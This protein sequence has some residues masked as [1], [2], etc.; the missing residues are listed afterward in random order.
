MRTITWLCV[1]VL[2]MLH[3]SMNAQSPE[4]YITETDYYHFYINREEPFNKKNLLKA[5]EPYTGYISI[6]D[7]SVFWD[8]VPNAAK[9]LLLHGFS[10]K[11]ILFINQQISESAG[12]VWQKKKLAATK[13][14]DS[15]KKL[16]RRNRFH[17]LGV[18]LFSLDKT[19]C[20]IKEGTSCRYVYRRRANYC[21]L[22]EISIYSY[23][24]NKWVRIKVIGG[25]ITVT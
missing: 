8:N 6:T 10:E 17:A 2:L 20:I 15:D 11:D 7:T 25:M 9:V 12:F 14:I 13:V 23:V 19:K 1:F 16:S 24:N 3:I 4:T 18:P 21:S 22:S 5:S